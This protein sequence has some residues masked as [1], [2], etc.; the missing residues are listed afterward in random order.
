[1]SAVS[2]EGQSIGSSVKLVHV[3]D[4]EP[5]TC[6]SVPTSAI[7]WFT[8]VSTFAEVGP[9]VAGMGQNWALPVVPDGV[10]VWIMT[11]PWVYRVLVPVP[12]A[13][14]RHWTSASSSQYR[15]VTDVGSA[16]APVDASKVPPEAAVPTAEAYNWKVPFVAVEPTV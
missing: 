12:C 9:L 4:G 8:V 14:C 7:V 11:L 16:S 3:I 5:V 15:F 2:G 13:I 1:M 6:D 10:A